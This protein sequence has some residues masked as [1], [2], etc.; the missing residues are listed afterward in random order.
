MSG[1]REGWKE[2]DGGERGQAR[3]QTKI[4]K[5]LGVKR[6]QNFETC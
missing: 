4:G 2:R 6:E 5:S 3:G 1:R